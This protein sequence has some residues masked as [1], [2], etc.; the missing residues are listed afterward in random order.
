MSGSGRTSRWD[1]D[2]SAGTPWCLYTFVAVVLMAPSLRFVL[3]AGIQATGS[4]G[5][6]VWWMLAAVGATVL[7]L[8]SVTQCVLQVIEGER[9]AWRQRQQDTGAQDLRRSAQQRG[10]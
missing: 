8:K 5:G 3:M 1:P 2:A 7:A 4:V 9:A 10:T 6:G